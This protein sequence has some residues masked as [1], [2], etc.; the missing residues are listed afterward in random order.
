MGGLTD[1]VLTSVFVIAGALG[2]KLL[3]QAVMGT[4]NTG[5]VGYGTSAL[6]GV[7]LWAGVRYMIKNKVAAD[8]TLAGAVVNIIL[9]LLNDYTPFGGYLSQG[10][11]DYQA[12][13]F[14]TPQVLVDPMNNAAIRWPQGLIAA[15]Q[16][17]PAPPAVAANGMG[18]WMDNSYAPISVYGQ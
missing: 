4:S 3:T 9:R 11:G 5:I 7:M 14:L 8:G 10:F 2:T 12:Q 16:P 17:P 15:V 13:A 18:G 1:T 6:I